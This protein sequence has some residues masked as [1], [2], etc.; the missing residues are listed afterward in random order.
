VPPKYP[1]PRGGGVGRLL[2]PQ[3]DTLDVN[4]RDSLQLTVEA[5]V[6]GLDVIPLL[7]LRDVL[8]ALKEVLF[9]LDRR[10]V[11]PS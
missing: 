11:L 2:I 8:G 9:G 6:V 3:L 4:I 10:E 7:M 5:V 1:I